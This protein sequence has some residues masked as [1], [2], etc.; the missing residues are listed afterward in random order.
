MPGKA[1]NPTDKHLGLRLRMR[2]K[3]LHM[4]QAALGDAV[5]VTF[6][7]I[8]KYENGSNRAGASRLQQFSNVLQVP[9]S[10]FFEGAPNAATGEIGIPADMAK[11]FTTPQG[12]LLAA[13]FL[14]I[15]SPKRRQKIL[16]LVESLVSS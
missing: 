9:V 12:L 13:S 2:R 3:M 7:Q 10:F 16:E 6:Q 11:F 5:G 14:K 1:P 4:S 15:S 8:Q